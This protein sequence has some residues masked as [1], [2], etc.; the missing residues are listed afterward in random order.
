MSLVPI[1]GKIMSVIFP[2]RM[3]RK[4]QFQVVHV[5]G[6]EPGYGP[7]ELEVSD[8]FPEYCCSVI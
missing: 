8:K 4:L 6:H 1:T 3:P 2:A 5:S 7:K